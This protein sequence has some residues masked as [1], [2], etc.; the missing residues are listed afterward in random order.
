M[1]TG[2]PPTNLTTYPFW[3]QSISNLINFLLIPFGIMYMYSLTY[4]LILITSPAAI[5]NLLINLFCTLDIALVLT[6]DDFHSIFSPSPPPFLSRICYSG[7]FS[8]LSHGAAFTM[9]S[10]MKATVLDKSSGNTSTF[11]VICL[12]Q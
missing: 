4:A 9:C 2:P 1:A 8:K 7:T 10:Q 5:L 6:S 12:L 3:S 11:I